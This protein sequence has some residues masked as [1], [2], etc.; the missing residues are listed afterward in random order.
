MP[1]NIEPVIPER[2]TWL[3]AAGQIPGLLGRRFAEFGHQLYLVG[4]TVRDAFLAQASPGSGDE[5]DFATDARPP[6]IKAVLEGWAEKVYTT[7]EAFGT[8]AGIKEGSTLEITTFRRDVY[9]TD[10][11]H[12]EVSFSNTIEEDLERRDFTVN[13]L[14][15]KVPDAQMVDPFGG[16]ADLAR[17]VL[18][19]PTSPEKTFAD[20]PL[21]M[22]RLFRFWATLEF[23]PAAP[24]LQAV[25]EMAGRLQIVSAER[26]R[27][28]LSK[29]LTA[30]R[31]A[32]A[33]LGLVRSGLAEHFLPELSSL[34]MEQDPR[35][36]HKD[37]LAHSL[38]VVEKASP[39]LV[40][41]LACLLHDI[42]KPDT[43]TY[44]PKGVSFHH[45][46]MVGARLSRRRLEELR[47]RRAVID[48]VTRLVELHLRPHTLK[49]G[50]SDSAVRRYVRDAGP[51]LEDL[52]EL[53]R[54]DVTTVNRRRAAAIQN[55]IDQLEQRIAELKEK[56]DLER[57]RPPVNGHRIMAYLG[58]SPGPKVGEIMQVLLEK[59]IDEGPYSEH[60]ALTIARKWALDEG[61]ED[62]GPPPPA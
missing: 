53:V 46:E 61:L 39:R 12:P 16:L 17:R 51:L 27:D 35:H 4:G 8:V 7:G 52:N 25:A 37:V 48:D 50:W 33:L 60:E 40:L 19:T 49:M 6:Q 23:Q 22:L 58:M 57:L 14:A 45:H 28:E 11:R 5:Y 55:R 9:R 13:A 2:L 18:T 21:R 44:G 47:Y 1:T 36:R 54:C 34:E 31:P 62:P 15:I 56:E 20:D 29:L 41:R 24:T 38:A 3:L 43:R 32:E 59:R 26:I 30:P 42:G 10:S